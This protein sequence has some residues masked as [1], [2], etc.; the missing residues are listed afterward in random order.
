[1]VRIVLGIMLSL[2]GITLLCLVPTAPDRDIEALL[3]LGSIGMIAGSTLLF[4]GYNALKRTSKAAQ[5]ISNDPIHRLCPSC[6]QNN[7]QTAA[8]TPYIRGMILAHQYGRKVF[9]GCVPCVRKN[10]IREAGISSL[11]GWYSIVAIVLNPLFIIYNIL[12]TPF[13]NENNRKA[14]MYL[15]A[16]GMGEDNNINITRCVYQ[17]AISIIK[18]DGNTNENKLTT[19]ITLGQETV[20]HFDKNEFLAQLE[21]AQ[22]QKTSSQEISKLLSPVLQES[23][24]TVVCSY[25]W[26]IALADGKVRENEEAL[27]REF[28]TNMGLA[29]EKIKQA[30]Y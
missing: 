1:M 6:G 2:S 21:E 12:Q 28:M 15:D 24:K 18:I 4:F 13:I 30:I 22:E 7:I 14:R 29:P 3:I 16:Y 25:L 9:I 10:I 17:L 8:V 23:S 20:P 5:N 11:I 27:I 26:K 19:A